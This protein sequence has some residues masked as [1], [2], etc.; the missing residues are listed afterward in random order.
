M[1]LQLSEY[2]ILCEDASHIVKRM[3]GPSPSSSLS[4]YDTCQCAHL[5]HCMWRILL[6]DHILDSEQLF[7]H[8]NL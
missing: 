3:S 8:Y 1:P 7:A 2:V 6:R 5:R 4:T